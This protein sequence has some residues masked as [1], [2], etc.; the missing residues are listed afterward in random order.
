MR[1]FAPDGA[2]H[3]AVVAIGNF[4]GVHRG[5]KAVIAVAQARAKA[6]G[7]PAGVLHLRAASAGLLQSPTAPLFRLTDESSRNCGCSRRPGSIVRSS[8]PSTRL[9]AGLYRRP[10]C[11]P[12]CCVERFSWIGEVIGFNFHFGKN[13]AGTPDF[14]AAAGAKT[15]GFPVD[16]VPPLQDRGQAVSSGPIRQALGAGRARSRQPSFWAILGSCPAT[17]IHG[18]KR[19]RELG[20]PTANLQARRRLWA[21]S[22]RLCGTGRDSTGAATTAWSKFGRRP[23]FD[24]GVVLLEVFVF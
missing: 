4:D 9:L 7:R 15:T 8:H 13:R 12:M 5:H 16:V 10:V 18:D 2:M 1:D 14:L 17:V 6:L 21:A 3:G 20:F 19:G 11:H 23:M 24:S 22:R